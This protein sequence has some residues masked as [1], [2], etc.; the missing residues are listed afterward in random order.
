M[1]LLRDYALECEAPIGSASDLDQGCWFLH[2][3]V[4]T[5]SVAA[6]SDDEVDSTAGLLGDALRRLTTGSVITMDQ[7][8]EAFDSYPSVLESFRS[9]MVT[10]L[11]SDQRLE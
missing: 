5:V 1:K 7:L 3:V 11:T 8:L 10:Q 9:Q 4:K 2:D 6:V